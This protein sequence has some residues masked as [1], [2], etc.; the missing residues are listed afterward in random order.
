MSNRYKIAHI[1]LVAILYLGGYVLIQNYITTHKFDFLTEFDQAVPLMP[2]YIWLYHSLIPA[3]L[4]TM[5]SLVR[6]KKLFLT[7]FWSCML[8]GLI[9]NISYICFPSFYPREPFEINTISEAFLHMTRQIDASNNTFPSGHVTFAWIMF[10][11]AS[12]SNLAKRVVGIRRLYLLWA[13]GITMSTLVLKQHYIVDVI[14]GITLAVACFYAARSFIEHYSF[15][16]NLIINDAS[17]N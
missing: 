8:A 13:I 10:L 6:T 4:L 12:S 11:G 15:G 7:T 3:I 5:L 17:D 16:S 1:F 2:E 14:S 9:L